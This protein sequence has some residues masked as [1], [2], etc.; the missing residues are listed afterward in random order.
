MKKWKNE[1][2][3]KWKNEK[4]KKWKN[5]KMKTKQTSCF[6]FTVVPFIYFFSPLS[7]AQM[8]QKSKSFFFILLFFFEIWFFF[9][10]LFCFLKFEIKWNDNKKQNEN[11]KSSAMALLVGG[12]GW[13]WCLGSLVSK[14]MWN[15]NGK[16]DWKNVVVGIW[17][18]SN[19]NEGDLMYPLPQFFTTLHF[20]FQYFI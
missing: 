6:G 7:S 18:D 13:W 3:K 19:S 10:V 2:M 9:F 1:K 11:Q 5:E 17:G 4:M 15:G 8:G 12:V 16:A 20:I 14:K